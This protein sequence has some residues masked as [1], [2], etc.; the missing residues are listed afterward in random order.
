VGNQDKGSTDGGAKSRRQVLKWRDLARD[1]ELT[2][3]ER[4]VGLVMLSHTNK[5]GECWPGT[6]RL[7]ALCGRGAKAVKKARG[8]LVQ[9]GYFTKHPHK[10][11]H[12]RMD[13]QRYRPT[14][15]LVATVPVGVENDTHGSATVGVA[16]VGVDSGSYGHR[17]GH[18][19]PPLKQSNTEAG[20]RGRSP[21]RNKAV[22]VRSQSQR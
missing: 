22:N 14:E 18:Q 13:G 20:V 12:G 6:T 19:G 5:Q 15:K 1:E 17:G 7:Q 10:D 16:T 21:R 3:E 4:F 8:G 9:K 11:E 2:P